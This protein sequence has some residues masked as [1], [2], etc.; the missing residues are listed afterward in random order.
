MTPHEPQ[1]SFVV[2]ARDEERHLGRCLDSILT[3]VDGQED[4]EVIVVE[5]GSHDRTAEIARDYAAR[6]PR[7]HVLRSA[8]SNQAEAMNDGI[9]AAGGRVVARV[10]AHGYLAPDYLV[11]ALAALERY[12]EVSGVG[13]RFLPCGETFFERVAGA[14]RSTPFGV[15]GG[16]GADRRRGDHVVA[17]VQ[18][19]VYRRAALVAAG[20][21]DPAMAYGEDEE[22][23]WRLR[24]AG[25]VVLCPALRQFYRPR[26]SWRALVRQY[27]HYGQGRMRVLARHPDYLRPRHLA[28]AVL[29][30][31]L[32]TLGLGALVMPALRPL[33]AG[34]AG[35]WGLVL[36]AAGLTA[37]G[38]RWQER[39]L[40]PVAVAGMHVAY[41]AGLLRQGLRW[42]PRQPARHTRG[43]NTLP[44]EETVSVIVCTRDRPAELTR[45][46][47]SIAGQT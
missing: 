40:V 39:L 31:L 43:R 24:A 38:A 33:L 27:W 29:V 7:I 44:T 3:Q 4:V 9:L 30:L 37:P 47:A 22:L 17:S 23:N 8:A 2:P 15:G 34:V 16:Y 32:A 45:C 28:P 21:F 46:L 13:G 12:P 42:R 26:G 41:G 20:L 14:A 19:G 25:G 35:G 11:T 36:V 5:N 6:D 1:V 10:D 18:C